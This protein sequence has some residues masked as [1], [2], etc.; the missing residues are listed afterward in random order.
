MRYDMDA[1]Q[2]AGMQPKTSPGRNGT[3][4]WLEMDL[5]LWVNQQLAELKLVMG[6]AVNTHG[7]IVVEGYPLDTHRISFS[8]CEPGTAT[9]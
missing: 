3:Y 7:E 1:L 5:D 8:G 9:A 4:E 2:L 6:R